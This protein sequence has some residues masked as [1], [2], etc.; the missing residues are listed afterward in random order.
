MAKVLVV[1]FFYLFSCAMALN[2]RPIVGILTEDTSGSFAEHGR[3]YL[4]ASYVKFVESAGARVVPILN[5]LTKS[6]LDV[7]LNSVN[8]VLF[9][10]GGVQL[11]PNG[12]GYFDTAMMIYDYFLRENSAGR[13]FPLWGTCLG[14]EALTVLVSGSNLL[15]VYDSENYSIPLM[16]DPGY[17][18]SRMFKDAPKNILQYL[19]TE[20][21]TMNNH[22]YG[23]SPEV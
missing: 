16:F 13:Y 10:G 8:G 7:I 23:I 6:E 3:M 14:F 18:S 4:A 22:R 20:D 21:V 17:N 2:E 1:L 5:N 12:S 9:P 15:S 19:S 11:K